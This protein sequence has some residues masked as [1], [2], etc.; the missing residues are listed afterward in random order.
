MLVFFCFMARAL[1]RNAYSGIN[2]SKVLSSFCTARHKQCLRAALVLH[3]L[4]AG[5]TAQSVHPQAL[6][7]TWEMGMFVWGCSLC[8]CLRQVV[9]GME[10]KTG[11][12]LTQVNGDIGKGMKA[13]V[14]NDLHVWME[15]R[16]RTSCGQQA[17]GVFFC[18]ILQNLIQMVWLVLLSTVFAVLAWT[19]WAQ[20]RLGVYISPDYEKCMW[21]CTVLVESTH[22]VQLPAEKKIEM[23]S[24]SSADAKFSGWEVWMKISVETLV[25]PYSLWKLQL[26]AFPDKVFHWL[27]EPRITLPSSSCYQCYQRCHKQ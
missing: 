27:W 20:G 9:W 5:W 3:W 14:V 2:C 21:N 15:C 1:V 13:L 18:S 25:C 12:E 4:R 10:V 11:F 6:E 7:A 22:S 19:G 23:I 16:K 24:R 17:S 26:T 8:A